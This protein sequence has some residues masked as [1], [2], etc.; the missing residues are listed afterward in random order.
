MNGILEG[1]KIPFITG[2]VHGRLQL[3]LEEKATGT[4]EAFLVCV[5]KKW[6]A[7]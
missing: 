6:E 2:I 4:Q 3:L 7:L 5:L 1:L